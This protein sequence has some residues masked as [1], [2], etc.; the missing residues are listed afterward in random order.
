MGG[1]GSG[2]WIRPDTKTA[3]EDCLDE[4]NVFQ[5]SSI[6]SSFI[7][8]RPLRFPNQYRKGSNNVREPKNLV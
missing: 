6:T 1:L 2:N 5:Y 3:V 8:T 4:R 7:A